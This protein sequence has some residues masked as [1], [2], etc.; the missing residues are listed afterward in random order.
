MVTLTVVVLEPEVVVDGEE[1]FPVVVL[2]PVVVFVVTVVF[3]VVVFVWFTF[4]SQFSVT[5]TSVCDPVPFPETSMFV[6]SSHGLFVGVGVRLGVSVGI[7]VTDEVGVGPFVGVGML[8]V[9]VTNDGA[10]E[11]TLWTAFAVVVN[12]ANVTGKNVSAP[13]LRILIKMMNLFMSFKF[14]QFLY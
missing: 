3:V 12:F 7:G 5:F 6:S 10:V 14:M 13:K 11:K 4:V 2:L 8:G 1:V 9:G